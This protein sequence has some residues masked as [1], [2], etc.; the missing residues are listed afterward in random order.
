[1]AKSGIIWVSND[2]SNVCHYLS[3]SGFHESIPRQTDGQIDRK[4]GR[5]TDRQKDRH[6]RRTDR[7][8]SKNQADGQTSRRAGRQADKVR[9][10]H[11]FLQ[12]NHIPKGMMKF[13]NSPCDNY[14]G[15]MHSARINRY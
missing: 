12:E 5:Q 14:Q 15:T 7:Q 1:M 13:Q 8:A 11:S 6:G 4:I 2:D 9:R 10:E 3:K